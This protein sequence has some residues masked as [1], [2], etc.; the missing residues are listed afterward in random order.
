MMKIFQLAISKSN[1]GS[2]DV[3]LRPVTVEIDAG[4][5]FGTSRKLCEILQVSKHLKFSKSKCNISDIERNSHNEQKLSLTHTHTH[6]NRKRKRVPN[7]EDNT[8]N[9][10]KF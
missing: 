7:K 3:R 5:A 2:E 10:N 1:E 8:K 6:T 4:D 9:K